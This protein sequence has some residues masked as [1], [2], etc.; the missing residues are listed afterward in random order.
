MRK[1]FKPILVDGTPEEIL[2]YGGMFYSHNEGI[3]RWFGTYKLR[4][5]TNRYLID[6]YDMEGEDT[7]PL[8]ERAKKTAEMAKT[9]KVGASQYFY[10][11]DVELARMLRKVTQTRILV[12]DVREASP[13]TD[14]VGF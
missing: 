2:K 3:Y 7:E 5:K 6:F 8:A 12:K 10:V 14:W 1:R 9:G 11:S 4:Y 13:K